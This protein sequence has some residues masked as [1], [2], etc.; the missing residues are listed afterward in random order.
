MNVLNET[1]ALGLA[2]GVGSNMLYAVGTHGKTKAKQALLWLIQRE[3]NRDTMN[4]TLAAFGPDADDL[5]GTYDATLGTGWDS[6]DYRDHVEAKTP[7]WAERLAAHLMAH[8]DA[9]DDFRAFEAHGMDAAMDFNK[10]TVG[11][12]MPVATAS[13]TGAFGNVVGDGTTINQYIAN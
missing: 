6:N 3:K 7:E 2:L 9:L 8:P 10:V 13:G 4:Q 12:N 11:G 1:V 5:A